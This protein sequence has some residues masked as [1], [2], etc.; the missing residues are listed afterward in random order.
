MHRFVKTKSLIFKAIVAVAAAASVALACTSSFAADWPQW[1][2]PNRD[3][4][5]TEK[6]WTA[7]WP[8]GG[9]KV[10]WKAK[11]GQGHGSFAV[12]GSRVYTMGFVVDPPGP[13]GKISRDANNQPLG[14]ATVWCFDAESGTVV[15]KHAEPGAKGETNST[16]TVAAG[17]VYVLQ[18]FGRLLC[19]DAADGHVVWG[20]NLV[21]DFHATKPYYGYACSPLVVGDRLIVN[22][23]GDDTLVLALDR[24][25]GQPVWR[26]GKGKGNAGFASPILYQDGGKPAVA[27]FTP[28]ATLGLDPASGEELWRYPWK[29]GRSTVATPVISDN[30]VFLCGAG[31]EQFSVLL[32][33]GSGGPKEIWKNENL[34][35][36][37]QSDVLVDGHV[38]GTHN[39][40]HNPKNASLRCIRFDTG[41]VKWEQEGFGHAPVTAAD[42]KLL[43]MEEKGNLIVAEASP[44]GYKELAR[45]KVLGGMCWTCPVLCGGRI[46]CRNFGGDV[47]CLDV[48]GQ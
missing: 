39:L 43:V 24:K 11:I 5:S 25:T 36:Y 48:K 26:G 19:L 10:L 35:S 2:G 28:T 3:G 22:C 29:L 38:Y 47:V 45:A 12:V 30:K 9:P 40:D 8:D 6:G 41:E 31:Q 17:L 14:N 33:L 4:V 27:V 20:K 42:G 23:G 37:F 44:A 18:M 34:A 16:P 13:G 1:R 7:H 15:W 46:Y 21:D 32:E